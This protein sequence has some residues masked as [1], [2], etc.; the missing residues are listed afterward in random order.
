MGRPCGRVLV[1]GDI[2]V[3]RLACALLAEQGCT[4]VHLLQPT[5][6]DLS[7]ALADDVSAVAVLVDGDVTA[8]RY[9][10]LAEHLRPGVRLVVTLFD[11][12]VG[13][14]LIRVVPNC[15]VTSPA[16]VS[17]PSVIG[18]CLADD[19]LVV[20]ATSTPPIVL[21][22]EAGE[23]V[24]RPWTPP[25]GRLRSLAGSAR[26]QLRV[27]DESARTLL[28]GLF[29]LVGAIVADWLLSV[30]YLH[31]RGI[32]A[33]YVAVRIVAGVG[34]ADA[35]HVPSWYLAVASLLMLVTIASTAVFTAGLVNWLLSPRYTSFV[36]RR[37]VPRSGHVV[38]I[39]VGQVGLRLCLQLRALGIPVVGVERK[40]AKL[41]LRTAKS[42]GI[43]VVVADGADRRTL[44]LLSLPRARALAAMGSDALDN[45][46]VAIAALAVAP[47]V[48]V[49]LR[50][51]DDDAIAETQSL[52]RIGQV[53]H[54]SGMTAAAVAAGLTGTDPLHVYQL[55]HR[56]FVLH[57]GGTRV[58]GPLRRCSC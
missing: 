32:E 3:A 7:A 15:L 16:T 52:F 26:I 53:R 27:V 48:R 10:L 22:Q 4:V 12:T 2:E 5:A 50:A 56:L 38:V 58:C 54:V 49:V 28:L 31:E 43:P 1:V 51:G 42:Q 55:D 11:Q 6:D 8:L 33:F 39:G 13:N 41:N 25:V 37:T 9:A 34:P 44:E 23:V 47:A 20:D 30:V 36:G 18:A 57:A 45:V 40:S 46:E 14:Q 24:E 29:G 35:E 17:A 19:L 21:V